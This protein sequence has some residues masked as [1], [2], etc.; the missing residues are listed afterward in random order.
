MK[1]FIF[2]LLSAIFVSMAATSLTSCSKDSDDDDPITS[3]ETKKVLVYE[4][5]ISPTYLDFYDVKLTLKGENKQKEITLK[6]TDGEPFPY[7]GIP[8]RHITFD[9][10][11]GEPG[12]SSVKATATPKADIEDRLKSLDQDKNISFCAVSQIF[13]ADYAVNGEYLVKDNQVS[14]GYGDH[15]PAEMLGADR[16]GDLLYKSM[17]IML[18]MSLTAD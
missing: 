11:D 8:T 15:T 2:T 12:V 16:K 1:K 5:F 9:R 18:G 7:E 14:A 3:T 6:A 13:K 17:A 10:I 4:A